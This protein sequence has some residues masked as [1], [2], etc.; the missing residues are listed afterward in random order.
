MTPSQSIGSCFYPSSSPIQHHV[1]LESSSLHYSTVIGVADVGPEVPLFGDDN[2]YN[3]NRP[4]G[5]FSLFDT[6][7]VDANMD[8]FLT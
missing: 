6:S 8:P 2:E 1:N 7:E 4:V 5:D 3:T